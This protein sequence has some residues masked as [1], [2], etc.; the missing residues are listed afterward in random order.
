MKIYIDGVTSYPNYYLTDKDEICSIELEV[1]E[2]QYHR[3]KN[4]ELEWSAT[5]GL[6]AGLMSD[7]V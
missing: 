5:Q 3:I 4:A 2:D 7:A 6:L 1:T